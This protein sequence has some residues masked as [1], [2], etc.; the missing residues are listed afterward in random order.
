MVDRLLASRDE[1]CVDRRER[2]KAPWMEEAGVDIRRD[3]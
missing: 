2:W 1:V 3:M